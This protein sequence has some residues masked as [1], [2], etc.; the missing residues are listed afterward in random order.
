M[1]RSGTE[2]FRSRRMYENSCAM[3]FEP[4]TDLMVEP[5]AK[6]SPRS[7]SDTPV[8][9]AYWRGGRRKSAIKLLVDAAKL[10]G[11]HGRRGRRTYAS[12]AGRARRSSASACLPPRRCRTP[13]RRGRNRPSGTGSPHRGGSTGQPRPTFDAIFEE[14]VTPRTTSRCHH[15]AVDPPPPNGIGSFGWSTAHRA[16]GGADLIEGR[17]AFTHGYLK[18]R[19]LD[20]DIF[21]DTGPLAEDEERLRTWCAIR[22]LNKSLFAT[23]ACRVRQRDHSAVAHRAGRSEAGHVLTGRHDESCRRFALT[24]T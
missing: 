12:G 5:F 9:R 16:V 18:C 7:L 6:F 21:K 1:T 14:G 13:S 10:Q 8:T 22:T 23:F 4:P 3:E 24:N 20:S 2:D 17:H 19:C 15:T 11:R